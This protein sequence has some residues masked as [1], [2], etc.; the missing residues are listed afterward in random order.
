MIQAT[1]NAIVGA[2]L[3]SFAPK[4]FQRGWPYMRHGWL[5]IQVAMS[6]PEA[7]THVESRRAISEGTWFI[8]GGLLW[9]GAG[10]GAVIAGLYLSW[11]AWDFLF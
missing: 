7:R 3:L 4:A 9:L 11:L 10:I 6:W 5:A 2:V 1:L 8:I